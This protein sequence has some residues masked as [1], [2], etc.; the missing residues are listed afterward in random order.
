MKYMYKVRICL[1]TVKENKY[2]ITKQEILK[3]TAKTFKLN[4]NDSMWSRSVL[5]KDELGV[6]DSNLNN[7]LTRVNDC[8]AYCLKEDIDK[9]YE[10][11]LRWINI[12]LSKKEDE[13]IRSKKGL[14]SLPL[15]LGVIDETTI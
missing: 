11:L 15:K 8:H 7:D 13:L 6:I 5:R 9:T 14:E 1:E 2:I 10:R 12:Q 4:D 3:E